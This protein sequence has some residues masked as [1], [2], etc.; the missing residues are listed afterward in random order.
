MAKIPPGGAGSTVIPRSNGHTSKKTEV[1]I[2][3]LQWTLPSVN[4]VFRSTIVYCHTITNQR[5]DEKMAFKPHGKMVEKKASRALNVIR[6]VKG[7][8]DKI[9]V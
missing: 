4:R 5:S 1:T 9:Y 2:D 7:I 6:E 8:V 3:V